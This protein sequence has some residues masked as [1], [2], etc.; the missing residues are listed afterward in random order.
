MTVLVVGLGGAGGAIARY[1]VGMWV[2]GLTG[3]AFPWGT[4]TVNL[5]GS[6]ALGFALAW[7]P[8]AAPAPEL[9]ALVAVGFLGSFTTFS[10]FSFEALA[11]VRDGAWVPAAAYTLGSVALGVL[12]VA[13]GAVLATTLGR[14]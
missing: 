1:F 11:M 4:F 7:L 2:Q 10:A 14:A 3:A 12:G 6:F 9:R 8:Y 5:T 13:A